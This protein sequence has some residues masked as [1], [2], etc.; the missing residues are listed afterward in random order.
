MGRPMAKNLLRTHQL[1]VNDVVA[2]PVAQ[3]AELGAKPGSLAQ[4]ADNCTVICTVLPNA[5]IVKQVLMGPDGL[6]EHLKAGTLVIDLSS[7]TPTDSQQYAQFLADKGC[8]FVDAPVSGGE[9]KAIDATLAI[10]C[11]GSV[12]DFERA[13]PVLLGMG[14]AA[15]RVGDVGAGS[16][17]KLANQVIVNLTI[18]AVGEAMVLATK[19]GVGVGAVY[20]AIRAGLAGSAVLDAK[21]P[22]MAE[23]VFEPGGTLAI[24]KKDIT[25]VLATAKDL[26]VPMPLTTMLF[27]I[28][29]DL[30]VKDRLGLDHSALVTYF[31]DLAGIS[32][33]TNP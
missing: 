17:T 21:A 32:V 22:M 16:T 14:S 9:P 4:L 3:L 19:A 5:A 1:W 13:K 20:D 26:D 24:N 31:E 7:V 8:G 33:A 23:H 18:A 30:S 15:T 27:G 12:A 11:G 2:E 6:G 10:M 29:E 25:N 28:M